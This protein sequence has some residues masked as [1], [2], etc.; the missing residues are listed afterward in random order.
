MSSTEIEARL[1]LEVKPKLQEQIERLEKANFDPTEAAVPFIPYVGRSYAESQ[2][3]A[4]E[5]TR[6]FIVGKAT[7]GWGWKEGVWNKEADLGDVNLRD[8]D[9]YDELWKVPHELI[10][11][12]IVPYYSGGSGYSSL[13]WNRIYRIVA[14][15]LHDLR[16]SEVEMR[17]LR[18]QDLCQDCFDSIAWTNVFKIGGKRGNPKAKLRKPQMLLNTLSEEIKILEP[19]VVFFF[20]APGYDPFLRQVLPNVQIDCVEPGIASI[21]NLLGLADE[22]TAIRTYHPQATRPVAFDPQPIVKYVRDNR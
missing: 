15:L 8:P 16:I 7:D 20:T 14:D 22:G 11:R 9:W 2:N 4:G 18:K 1:R 6:I 3:C 10:E 17:G 21:D 13:F 12:K 5:R 19:D